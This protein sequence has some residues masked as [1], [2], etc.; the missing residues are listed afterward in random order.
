MH[1]DIEQEQ[2]V[3]QTDEEASF[4]LNVTRKPE[5]KVPFVK[6]TCDGKVNV[7]VTNVLNGSNV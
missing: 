4:Q 1:L 7:K 6:S 3:R 2:T 5:E